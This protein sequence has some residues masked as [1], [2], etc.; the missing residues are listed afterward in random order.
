M[1][2][3]YENTLQIVSNNQNKINETQSKI[4]LASKT[5]LEY[6]KNVE[7]KLGKLT[8]ENDCLHSQTLQLQNVV[9]P[10]NLQTSKAADANS[11]LTTEGPPVKYLATKMTHHTPVIQQD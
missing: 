11:D 8:A 10:A 9:D 7:Q 5:T 2:K 1:H 3:K 6:I 4:D